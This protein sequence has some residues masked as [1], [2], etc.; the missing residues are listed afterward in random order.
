M[1]RT[2]PT[3]RQMLEAEIERL[4]KTMKAARPEDKIAIEDII[5]ASRSISDLGG[6]IDDIDVL[7]TILFLALVKLTARVKKIEG[8]VYGGVDR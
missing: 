8:E 5:T 2:V 3:F 7:K 4:K 6:L 1:G